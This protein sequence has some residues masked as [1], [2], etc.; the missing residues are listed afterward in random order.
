MQKQNWKGFGSWE[1]AISGI[2]F[3]NMR[4]NSPP[5]CYIKARVWYVSMAVSDEEEEEVEEG[6]SS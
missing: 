2:I 6:S 3:R 5:G 4:A 1:G